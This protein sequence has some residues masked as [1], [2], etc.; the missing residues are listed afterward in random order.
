M[1]EKENENV[2]Q[3]PDRDWQN[4]LHWL[5]NSCGLIV[6]EE[7][8]K[9]WTLT[10]NTEY[11]PLTDDSCLR[12]IRTLSKRPSLDLW[13]FCKEGCR[14]ED[15][16]KHCHTEDRRDWQRQRQRPGPGPGPTVS[17]LRSLCQ[18]FF[19][20]LNTTSW[21]SVVNFLRDRSSC[22]LQVTAVWRRV[23]EKRKP[24]TAV[25]G[26]LA[27][28]QSTIKNESSP[29]VPL[30]CMWS[31]APP[32]TFTTRSPHVHHRHSLNNTCSVL[33]SR[34]HLFSVSRSISL[35]LSPTLL[36]WDETGLDQWLVLPSDV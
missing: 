4:D 15:G 28:Q 32:P 33:T 31:G 23:H 17:S 26:M 35:C 30:P 24:L 11:S 2:L 29:L 21:S 36:H 16:L 7:W 19:C 13:F 14:F 34:Q 20:Y 5:H 9:G 27:E 6:T 12:F 8:V 25:R 3:T 22:M 1:K 10:V 18:R